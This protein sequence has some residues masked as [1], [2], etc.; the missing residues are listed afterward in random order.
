MS[1]QTH[2]NFRRG[3]RRR[4]PL[5]EPSDVVERKLLGKFDGGRNLKR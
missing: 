2:P 4:D 5:L 3:R 1:G